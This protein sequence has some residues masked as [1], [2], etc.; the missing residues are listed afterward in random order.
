MF[1]IQ[2]TEQLKALKELEIMDSYSSD[3][4]KQFKQ[5]TEN[6]YNSFWFGS[7]S[8][9]IKVSLL[10]TKALEIFT[11]SA[12][13]QSFIK[14]FDDSHEELGVPNGCEIVWN[15]DGSATIIGEP[16]RNERTNNR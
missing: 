1:N 2:P 3:A 14:S 15:E 12:Q 9:S 13:A 4:L 16:I 8:P 11:K 7:V 5:L 10:G 6:A